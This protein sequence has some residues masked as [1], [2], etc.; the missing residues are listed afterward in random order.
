MSV[1]LIH[2]EAVWNRLFPAWVK[3]EKPELTTDQLANLIAVRLTGSEGKLLAKLLALG[4][5]SQAD[6]EVTRIVRLARQRG[7][8]YEFENRFLHGNRQ[9]GDH[10]ALDDAML[11]KYL[12]ERRDW[13]RKPENPTP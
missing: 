3:A 2:A 13:N 4:E 6:K 7:I 1:V 5:R 11:A 10:Y 9:P 12:P 8:D